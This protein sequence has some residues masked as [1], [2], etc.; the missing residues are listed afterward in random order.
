MRYHLSNQ[1]AYLES[2][3]TGCP[4]PE[5]EEIITPRTVFRLVSTEPPTMEDFK[6]LRALN[7]M[8]EPL[9]VAGK[10]CQ[11]RGLSVVLSM[12][13]CTSL[14]KLKTQRNKKVCAVT[15]DTGAGRIKNTA[16]VVRPTHHTW[17]PFAKFD[18]LSHS[19]IIS[20]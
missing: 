4:P 7:P 13:D 6:S 5:A 18:I 19:A 20:S 14:L 11:Y 12:D 1:M 8:G 3:P 16:T 15:L 2:L 10:E 9:R 17:W